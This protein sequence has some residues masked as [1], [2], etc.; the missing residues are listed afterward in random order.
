MDP[1]PI[2]FDVGDAVGG[3]AQ[4]AGS[5]FAAGGPAGDR[6]LLVC[7]PGGTYTRGY[8]D[9]QPPGHAAYSF[10]RA[11]AGE[12]FPVVTLDSLGTGE[13]TR[14]ERDIDLADQAAAAA[15]AVA[16]IPELLGVDAPPVAVGHSMG[17]YLAMAQQATAASYVGLAILGTTNQAVAQLDLPPEL[18]DAAATPEG[19]AALVEQMAAGMPEPYVTGDRAPLRS[20]FHLDDVPDEVIAA[21]DAATLTVVPRRCAAASTV[22]GITADAAGMIDVPVLL[23]YGE[24]D[25]SPEPHAEPAFFSASPD[26]TLFLLPGSGHCHNLATTRHRLWSR[27][28]AWGETAIR[29]APHSH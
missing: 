19:R 18:V 25:V 28:F 6:P 1:R 9:L 4:L 5:Y 15:A 21:D 29:P 12:G 11:A 10:A 23:A 22:P 26:V 13:S 14:P 24:V 17:G 16:T 7:L 20:W 2:T 8:W 3:P 27:L